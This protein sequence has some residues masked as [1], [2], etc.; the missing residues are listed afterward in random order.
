MV[1]EEEIRLLI[2]EMP[3]LSGPDVHVQ[4]EVYAHFGLAF[5]KFGLVEHSLIN[6]VTFR[7]VA[8]ALQR[9]LISDRQSWE[10]AFDT[11][12][13]AAVKLTFGNLVKSV[14][15]VDEFVDLEVELNAI[16]TVRDYFAHRFMR[17]EA[18]HAG[19]DDGCWLLLAKIA[20][21]RRKT[22]A[23]ENALRPRFQQMC[24]RFRILLPDD[25]HVDKTVEDYLSDA[26]NSLAAGK[27]KVGWE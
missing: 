18:H 6:I 21:V 17:D 23:L 14:L 13:A 16:K 8:D 1:S 15:K 19:S 25:A 12:H 4:K 24:R 11:S 26:A 9:R 7:H 22:L 5:M 2:E 27:A 10:L 20:V 3:E